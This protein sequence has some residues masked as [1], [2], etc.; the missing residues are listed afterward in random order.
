MPTYEYHCTHCN[1]IQEAFQKM[2]DA[3]LT[4]CEKCGR[5]TLKRGP[6]G[7]IGLSFK[8]SGFYITDYK[9]GQNP[10]Q[11]NKE[12]GSSGCC[13]CGKNGHS[14]SRDYP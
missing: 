8:G 5:D 11:K 9:E 3:P 1:H 2:S 4:T 7:G 12:S 13:P 14:C 10:P 6:G